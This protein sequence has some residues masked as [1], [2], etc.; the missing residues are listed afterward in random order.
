MVYL[1]PHQ[2]DCFYSSSGL[3]S[4]CTAISRCCSSSSS[5]SRLSRLPMTHVASLL[6]NLASHAILTAIHMLVEC[7]N[8]IWIIRPKYLRGWLC[9][10]IL[11]QIR[12]HRPCHTVSTAWWWLRCWMIAPCLSTLFRKPVP[13][14][15]ECQYGSRLDSWAHQHLILKRVS[16]WLPTLY[17]LPIIAILPFSSSL[18]TVRWYILYCNTL[19]NLL[20]C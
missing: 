5:P 13:S 2:S 3:S 1:P 9:S 6:A 18:P 4:A 12:S 11:V 10:P 20:A 15:P 17:V 8:S 19:A 7:H 14:P 16:T